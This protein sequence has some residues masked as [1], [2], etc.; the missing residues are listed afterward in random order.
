MLL[1]LVRLRYRDVPVFLSISSVLSQYVYLG[2]A[3]I[4]GA[5]GSAS[6]GL[7][8][9]HID[10]PTI[11]YS[12]LS[13]EDFS[14][15]L[16]TPIPSASIFSLAQSGWPAGQLM[17]MSFERINHLRNSAFV[18]VL[19]QEQIKQLEKFELAVK[20]IVQLGKHN[21]FDSYYGEGKDAN[22][23]YFAFDTDP[24]PETQELITQFKKILKLDQDI[25]VFR[26]TERQVNLKPNEI[27]IKLRSLLTL[28]G[29][30]AHG[31]EVPAAHLQ[32]KFVEGKSKLNND[33]F[34][35]LH[36]QSSAEEPDNAFVAIE[37]QDHWFFIEHSDHNS[38]Q[39]FGLLTYLYMLQAPQ[40]P[41][42]VP[43]ITIPAG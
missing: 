14:R 43:L 18:P 34:V 26:I 22:N 24:N 32:E 8:V 17:M 30:L 39:A 12:P 27:T 38:K 35:P 33:F 4:A 1:N 41:S 21:A 36:V 5:A 29:F 2:S 3:N 31:V 20:L 37:Y 13:G 15:Q 6:G 7:G 40:S 28:M 11:S 19:R 25:S 10:R 23:R 16:L 42:G 9:S